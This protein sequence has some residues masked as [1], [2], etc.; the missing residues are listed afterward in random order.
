MP[1]KAWHLH[2]EKAADDI[3]LKMKMWLI[4]FLLIDL[5]LQLESKLQNVRLGAQDLFLWIIYV[6]WWVDTV[7]TFS[8]RY[9][10]YAFIFQN[11][12]RTSFNMYLPD[13]TQKA[14]AH[15]QTGNI[16]IEAVSAEIQAAARDRK[17]DTSRHQ[18]ISSQLHSE[19]G[20]NALL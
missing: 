19:M 5:L 3:G 9:Q 1:N 8:S 17:S 20:S 15:P 4:N 6:V 2:T 14:N 18:H 16:Q 12:H 13:N 11:Y 7:C 10:S